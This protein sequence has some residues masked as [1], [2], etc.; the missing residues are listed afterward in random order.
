LLESLGYIVHGTRDDLASSNVAAVFYSILNIA[1]RFATIIVILLSASLAH[2]FGKKAVAV[3]GFALSTVL[4]FAF[5]VLKPTDVTGMVILTILSAVVYAPTIP[6]IWA[7]Y[8]DVADYSEWKTGR[9]FTGIVFATIGFALKAGLALGS[10][11][12]LWIMAGFFNYNTKLPAAPEAV[13]GYRI[14]AGIGVGILFA[15]CTVL[16]MGYKLNKRMTIQMAQ[17]LTERRKAVAS[18]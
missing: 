18:I 13:V 12:F 5:Y 3:V 2:R 4:G 10:A 15:I 7:I 11:S 17:E 8:A 14:C 9:R 1:G 6:L 16:L